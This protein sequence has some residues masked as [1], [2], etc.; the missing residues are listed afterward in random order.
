M[1]GCARRMRSWASGG[2]GRICS[3]RAC[4]AR[5]IAE[6]LEARY[7]QT[8]EEALAREHLERKRHAQA[9]ERKGDGAGDAAAGDGGVFDRRDLQDPAPVGRAGRGAWPPWTIWTRRRTKSRLCR[10][11]SRRWLVQSGM[12]KQTFPQGLK[13]RLFVWLMYGLKPVPFK[14][15]ST[16]TTSFPTNVP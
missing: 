8:N 7:G 1:R 2:C 11:L 14:N 3:R 12:P 4:A 6:T 5:L 13:P 15:R 16:S 10:L 9:G